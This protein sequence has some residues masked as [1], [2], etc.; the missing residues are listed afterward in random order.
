MWS[1]GCFFAE[2]LTGK[3]LLPGASESNQLQLIYDKCGSPN[4]E[5]WPGVSNYR[6]FSELGPK[7]QEGAKLHHYFKENS[8]VDK[9]TLDLIQQMLK[10]NPK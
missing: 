9:S 7:K 3:P 8:L 4:E 6:F 1:V 2:L 5:N 10:L